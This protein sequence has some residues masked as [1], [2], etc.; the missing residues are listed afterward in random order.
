MKITPDIDLNRLRIEARTGE[1]EW[2][3]DAVWKRKYMTTANL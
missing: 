3:K 2:K 1:G